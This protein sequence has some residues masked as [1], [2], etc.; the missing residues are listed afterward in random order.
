MSARKLPVELIGKIVSQVKGN[1]SLART[2]S[3]YL[4]KKEKDQLTN[5][6]N[7]NIVLKNCNLS[8]VKNLYLLG[9]KFTF[10]D[11]TT[12]ADNRCV[13]IA[14]FL[15][16]KFPNYSPYSELL[17]EFRESLNRFKTYVDCISKEELKKPNFISIISYFFFI[18]NRFNDRFNDSE[19]KKVIQM[20]IYLIN[21]N[22]Y[23]YKFTLKDILT[24]ESILETI[25]SNTSNRLKLIFI[26]RIINI[27]NMTNYKISKNDILWLFIK[28]ITP[29]NK[30]G[31][32]KIN[33][34]E[35]IIFV[36]KILKLFNMKEIFIE[37][38]TN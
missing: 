13:N 37:I 23:K 20:I 3:K 17:L 2:M 35:Y 1:P 19:S 26:E 33:I 16:E 38:I 28:Y 36:K 14:K 32:I 22:P 15:V 30:L 6:A 21:T 10:D 5:F 18:L 9:I 24:N 8:Q 12:A 27:L 31:I 34:S 11:V 25:N 7:K 4:S 29:E